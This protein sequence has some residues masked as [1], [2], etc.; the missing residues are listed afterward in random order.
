MGCPGKWWHHH[1]W[2]T[3]GCGT[4][5]CGAVHGGLRGWISSS[6]R[7]F[8]TLLSQILH[9]ELSRDGAKAPL[10]SMGWVKGGSFSSALSNPV[11]GSV[12]KLSCKIWHLRGFITKSGSWGWSR[13]ARREEWVV[14][15]SPS[16]P[17]SEN[18]TNNCA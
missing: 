6:W 16:T 12:L 13:A 8:P 1:P 18:M 15:G 3:S 9:M 11:F 4:A 17:A 2:K 14:R 7:S 5:Q 10:I